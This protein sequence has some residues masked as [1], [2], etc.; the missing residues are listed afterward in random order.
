ME[1]YI[2]AHDV[3]TI[4][5]KATLYDLQGTLIASEL[6][7]YPIYYPGANSVE[8]DP[9]D[10]WNAVCTATRLLLEKSGVKNSEI[11]VVSFSAQMMGCVLVD[12]NGDPMR[13]ALIW[14]DTRSTVQEKRMLD[15]VGMK[16]GYNITG[17]RISASYS[18]SKLLWVK[19]NQPEIYN[20]SA[21]ML[22]AK[23]F[24]I[25]RLTGKFVTDY[26]DACG[27]NLFDLKQKCWSEELISAYGVRRDLL[28]EALP[29]TAIAG[30]ITAEAARQTG[31][32]E[33]TPVVLGG[34][35]GSCASAGAGAV[36][37]GKIYDVLGTS[38]WISI[39]TKAPVFDENMRTFSWIHLDENL[40]TPNG[41]MQAGGVSLNWFKNT[42]CGEDSAKAKELGISVYK[43]IDEAIAQTAPGAGG[44]LH[45]P[46]FL[47]ERSPRWDYNA[48]GTFLGL[49]ASTTKAEMARAVLEGVAYNLKAIL[50]VFDDPALYP[51]FEEITFIGGGA[52]SKVWAQ[53]MADVWGI[54]VVIPRYLEEATSMGAAICGGVGVGAFPDFRVISKFNPEEWKIYPREEYRARYDA[55][56]RVF[57]QTY[58]ALREVYAQLAPLGK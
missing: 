16:N 39:V 24:I 55:M 20:K 4:G 45:L 26:S 19:D 10:W 31:L 21:K 51:K 15:T 34:G 44:V 36:E 52:K 8:Q 28:P 32:M 49:R 17:H 1:K 54:P 29:S 18:V 46:Y 48:S 11:A 13:R 6:V 41:T 27:T 42:F 35:D 9:E 57:N 7:E 50:D 3:G 40:Y 14:A 33:G 58:D 43:L 30:G 56:Y 53:I 12:K 25:R 5:D 47:G 38:S 22:N 37:E 2:L 23:D